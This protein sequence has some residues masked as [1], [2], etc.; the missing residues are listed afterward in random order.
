M[1]AVFEWLRG[2]AAPLAVR[3]RL[4]DCAEAEAD[5]YRAQDRFIPWLAL[6]GTAVA[7]KEVGQ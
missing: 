7:A 5:F 3:D 2:L 1:R 4:L 6:T